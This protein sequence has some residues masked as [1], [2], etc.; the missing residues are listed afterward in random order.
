MLRKNFLL[1]L[2]LWSLFFPS[3]FSTILEVEKVRGV[4]YQTSENLE[5]DFERC[6]MRVDK[7]IELLTAVQLFT[8][9]ASIDRSQAY[10]RKATHTKRVCWISLTP[11]AATRQ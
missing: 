4:P 7:R 5:A 8:S 6:S 9:W 2:M 10:G 1:A 11:L 3:A